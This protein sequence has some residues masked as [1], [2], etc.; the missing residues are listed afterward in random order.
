MIGSVLGTGYSCLN[1]IE[2]GQWRGYY[3]ELLG[4]TSDTDADPLDEWLY[5][6]TGL[7]DSEIEQE[8]QEAGEDSWWGNPSY[9]PEDRPYD[10]EDEF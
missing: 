7:T 4:A 2:A 8:R 10:P 1:L 3:T 6:A 9:D 5:G